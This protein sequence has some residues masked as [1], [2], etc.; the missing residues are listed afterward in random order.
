MKEKILKAKKPGNWKCRD[1]ILG[2]IIEESL[3]WSKA[4]Y[5]FLIK[6]TDKAIQRYQ[7]KT[8][9]FWFWSYFKI[10]L[11]IC[12]CRRSNNNGN[13]VI[14]KR[15]W[16]G[17]CSVMSDS[18][19]PFGLYS[20]WNSPGQNTRMGRLSFLQGIFPSQGSNPGLPH[21]RW[22]LYKLSHKGSP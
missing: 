8:L 18:L 16:S 12:L 19:W 11:N 5:V 20:P 1:G 21:C 15:L 17:S 7:K 22:I 3:F 6:F 10:L 13:S 9:S 2:R 14:L 4:Q